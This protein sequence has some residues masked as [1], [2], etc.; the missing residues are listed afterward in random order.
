MITDKI[1]EYLNR[2]KKPKTCLKEQTD[3]NS[4]ILELL[5]GLDDEYLDDRQIELKEIILSANPVEDD[6]VDDI[7]VPE[8]D[9]DND[10]ISDDFGDDGF[11]DDFA[12]EDDY[13]EENKPK[14]PSTTAIG[15]KDLYGYDEN[16]LDV[17]EGQKKNKTR[18][19][20]MTE[21]KIKKVKK[22]TKKTK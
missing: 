13:D 16:D 4:A 9:L 7:V 5:N 21:G 15:N 11:V 1:D 14:L 18:K 22:L 6:I 3:V 20:F 17:T 10:G 19:S 12:T 2:K 8:N